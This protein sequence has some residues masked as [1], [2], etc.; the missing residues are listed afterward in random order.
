MSI[1]MRHYRASCH[2]CAHVVNQIDASDEHGVKVVSEAM[3]RHLAET[4]RDIDEVRQVLDEAKE[5][6]VA[7]SINRSGE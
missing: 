2:Y 4:H 6:R 1:V 7:P 3:E 5:R